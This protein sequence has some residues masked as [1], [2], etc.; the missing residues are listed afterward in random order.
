MFTN[1]ILLYA[2]YEGQAGER[3]SHVIKILSKKNES[4]Y[5]QPITSFAEPGLEPW[6][7]K[8]CFLRPDSDFFIYS[9]GSIVLVHPITVYEKLATLTEMHKYEECLELITEFSAELDPEIVAKV[10]T[11]FVEYLILQ[12]KYE[13]AV[14]RIKAMRTGDSRWND[15]IPRFKELKQLNLILGG[16]LASGA[17]L[18]QSSYEQFPRQFLED[19]QYTELES[20]VLRLAGKIDLRRLLAEIN[21]KMAANP[22]L[23]SLPALQR[24]RLT[25]AKAI[26]SAELAVPLCI[27]L[28]DPDLFNI[29]GRHP[30]M[31]VPPLVLSLTE[32]GAE[33]TVRLVSGEDSTVKVR[34]A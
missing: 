33:A 17:H 2:I 31:R 13:D 6:Q 32:I 5:E 9:P 20:A 25:I 10:E 16:I 28:R 15:W 18:S 30:E 21:G 27:Q 29:L 7:Y 23:F 3:R 11:K 12:E 4:L 24:T 19:G 26:D 8:C 14:A 22:A 1:R 34:L